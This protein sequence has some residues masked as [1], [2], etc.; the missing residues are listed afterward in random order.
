[1]AQNLYSRIEINLLPPELRPRPAIRYTAWVSTVI[2]IV[3]VGLIGWNLFSSWETM[4]D[5]R[6]Q[7]VALAQQINQREPIRQ[8]YR[9]L[10]QIESDL[11][12][13]G[14]I[15]SMAS[16]DYVDMPV[17]LARLAQ[18]LPDGVYLSRI[19]NLGTT[20]NRGEAI[21]LSVTLRSAKRDEQLLIQTLT[22]LKQDPI[23]ADCYMRTADLTDVPLT[24]LQDICQAKWDVAMPAD[25]AFAR[26]QEYEFEVLVSL[27]RVL[28]KDGLVLVADESDFFKGFSLKPVANGA[29]DNTA[30]EVPGSRTPPAGNSAEG[31]S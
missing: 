20:K 26:N 24:T 25:S 8:D 9:E 11:R 29:D 27:S 31:A 21:E 18:L 14:K 23:M 22:N 4:R 2:I 13:Y 15:I 28:P 10:K 3:T 19:T 17:V 5:L 6:L 1:M 12:D 16:S 30:T 7:K